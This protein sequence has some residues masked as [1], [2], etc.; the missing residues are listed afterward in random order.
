M[1]TIKIKYV[2]MTNPTDYEY[3]EN[4]LT[5]YTISGIFLI[6]FAKNAQIYL[7]LVEESYL[8]GYRTPFHSKMGRSDNGQSHLSDLVDPWI[9]NY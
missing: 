5:T 1:K 6:N 4:R 8:I 3:F 9:L 7:I 2:L